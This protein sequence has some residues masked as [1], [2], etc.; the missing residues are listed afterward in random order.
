MSYFL[1]IDPGLSGALAFFDPVSNDLQVMDMPTHTITVNAKKKRRLDLNSLDVIFSSM[2]AVKT[3]IAV[4]EN[5]NAMPKQGVTSSF[6]FGFTA[7]ALN[8]FLAAKRIPF[9][10]VAP[11]TWKKIMRVTSDKDA[12]RREASRLMPMHAD[13]WRQVKDDGR[14]EAALLAYYLWTQQPRE[15]VTGL[16]SI[17]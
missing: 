9:V 5:V 1:G 3:T 13:K 6:N 8:A 14:A 4:I 17:L 16:E 7:G 11:A 12:T 10:S 2:L 15:K